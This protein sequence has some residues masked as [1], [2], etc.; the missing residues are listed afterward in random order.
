MADKTQLF[1]E[2]MALYSEAG[3]KFTM[4]ELATRLCISKKTL[5]EMVRSKEDLIIQVIQFYFE[6]VAALQD[7]IHADESLSSLQKLR[8]LLCATPDFAIRRHHLHEMKMNYPLAFKELDDKL[9]IGWERTFEVME[10]AKKENA[11]CKIDNYLFSKVYA[12]AIE[13]IIMG[14][15]A[16]PYYN[17]SQRQ[18]EI[19]DIL[20]FGIVNK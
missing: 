17:F 8:K 1:T 5:Y 16:Q 12:A 19:V 4:D 18:E 11:I 3:L 13:E 14:N 2:A 10:Q 20:I 15:D 7:A 9:R 6:K